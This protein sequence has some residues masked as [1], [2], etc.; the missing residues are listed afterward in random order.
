MTMLDIEPYYSDGEVARLLDPSGQ[1]I[2]ARSIRS[3]RDAGRL[4]G[5]RVA[6]KWMYR[7]TDVLNFLEAARKCHEQT[8]DQN[9]S[10]SAR[11]DGPSPGS[12]SGGLSE[13]KPKSTEQAFLPPILTRRR[14]TSEPGSASAP[15]RKET[16][17]VIPIKS[18]SPT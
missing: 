15:E 5:T 2:K 3:E 16:A 8:A 4:V 12:T 18:A 6:G 10:P 7:K 1:R 9:S 17:Q 11:R 14:P 13:A